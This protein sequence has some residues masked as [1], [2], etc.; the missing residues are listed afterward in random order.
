MG[1]QGSRDTT[2]NEDLAFL[3]DMKAIAAEAEKHTQKVEE[4]QSSIE[5]LN[6]KGNQRSRGAKADEAL[7]FLKAMEAMVAEA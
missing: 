7:A 2:T 6:N 4:L 5:K 3:R 1:N